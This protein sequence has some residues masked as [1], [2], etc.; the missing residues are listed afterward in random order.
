MLA[1]NITSI[2]EE[3]DLCQRRELAGASH[4]HCC[5]T[6]FVCSPIFV[7]SLELELDFVCCKDCKNTH[8]L[9]APS[10]FLKYNTILFKHYFGLHHFG[11]SAQLLIRR[12]D[13]ESKEKAQLKESQ[14]HAQNVRSIN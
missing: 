14:S 3:I 11:L 7:C 5:D 10:S 6:S 9:F 8:R 1:S 4:T 2:C 13:A 12:T